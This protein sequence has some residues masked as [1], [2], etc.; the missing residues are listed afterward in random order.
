MERKDDMRD[1]NHKDV[2]A[3]ADALMSGFYWGS[4]KEGDDYWH[5][6]HDRLLEMAEAAEQRDKEREGKRP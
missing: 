4:T 2:R 6:I 3:A 1:W 5:G